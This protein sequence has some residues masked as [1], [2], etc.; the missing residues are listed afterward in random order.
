MKRTIYTVRSV[1]DNVKKLID[2]GY[3][4][5]SLGMG[6]VVE[7]FVLEPYVDGYQSIIC[8]EAYTSEGGVGYHIRTADKISKTMQKKIEMAKKQKPLTLAQRQKR[9]AIARLK[10][11]RI[12]PDA[13]EQ[14]RKGDVLMRSEA[15][16]GGLYW[17]T[18]EEKEMVRQFERGY[19]AKA[20]L[21]VRANTNLG[22]MDSILYVSKDEKEW[23]LDRAELKGAKNGR[24][25]MSYTINHD[26]E[27]CSEFGR[28]IV[29]SKLGGVIRV[30]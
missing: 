28:I 6:D 9:E 10:I 3:I 27:L 22:L 21:V 30:G 8:T 17:L 16:F 5:H 14:F 4:K 25:V 24:V 26:N 2:H 11:L 15:P 18:E 20:Y 29:R 1:E 23:R 7:N 12:F 13:I 19:C